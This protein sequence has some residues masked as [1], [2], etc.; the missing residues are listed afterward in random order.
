MVEGHCKPGED[1]RDIYQ[2]TFTRRFR[3]FRLVGEVGTSF[4]S[5][6]VAAAAALVMATGRLGRN[7]SAEAVERRLEE[8]A[9]DL[10]APGFD[11]RYGAGLLDAAAALRP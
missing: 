10:G 11:P 2:E 4:A 5:P 8:T 6:H 1:G 3:G 9:R 7:P